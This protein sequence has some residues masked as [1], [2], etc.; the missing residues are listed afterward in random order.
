MEEQNKVSYDDRRKVM[1]NKTVTVEDLNIDGKEIGKMTQTIVGEYHE[2][3]IRQIYE[4]LTRDRTALEQN[5]KKTKERL[6]TLKDIE[7]D[8]ELKA[9]KEKIDKIH[10]LTQKEK[11]EADLKDQQE[12][13]DS[14][15]KSITLIKDAIGTRLKL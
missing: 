1:T 8:D 12:R 3:G 9:L 5:I 4:G 14:A 6:E 10:K 11:L 15:K 2:D 7:N 13:L